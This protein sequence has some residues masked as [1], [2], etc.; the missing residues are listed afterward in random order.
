VYET[1]D[2]PRSNTA[3]IG[4]AAAV[5]SVVVAVAALLVAHKDSVLDR[6]QSGG[7]SDSPTVPI[8]PRTTTTHEPPATVAPVRTPD[9]TKLPIEYIGTWEGVVTQG[10][11]KYPMTLTLLGA[12]SLGKHVGNTSYP[13]QPC[14]GSLTLLSGGNDVRLSENVDTAACVDDVLKLSYIEGHIQYE[15]FYQGSLIATANLKHH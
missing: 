15:A 9:E 11:A 3:R 13:A 2:R 8:V 4:A 14:N 5:A 10:A 6:K 12:A 1:D 7:I